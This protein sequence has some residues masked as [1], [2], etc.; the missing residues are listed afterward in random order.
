MPKL[1]PSPLFRAGT[2][3]AALAALFPLLLAAALPCSAAEEPEFKTPG[4][5]PGWKKVTDTSSAEM[6]IQSF[7]P[8][9]ENE[10]NWRQALNVYTITPRPPGDA[11]EGLVNYMARQAEVGC[12]ALATA[13]GETRNDPDPAARGYGVRYAQFQCPL[14]RDGSS[15]V[16]LLKAVSGTESVTLFVLM[17]QGPSFALSP[18]EPPVFKDPADF[19]AHQ[20]WLKQADDYLRQVARVCRRS[21]RAFDQCSQ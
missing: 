20:A 13:P 7:L 15:R 19:T 17:R 2:R 18:P 16:E 3:R 9:G 10:Q 4:F 12:R 11:A 5:W 14:R 21:N 1:L 8:A 6:R